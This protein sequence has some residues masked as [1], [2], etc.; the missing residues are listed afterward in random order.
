LP[1]RSPA[2]KRD[3]A[4]PAF[5]LSLDDDAGESGGWRFH[6][7]WA[8]SGPDP[9]RH[10]ELFEG[11]VFRR[12]VAYLVDVVIVGT[13]LIAAKAAAAILGVLSFGLLTPLLAVALGF[14]PLAYH[15]L[16]IG[17]PN[18][19]TLG[20]SLMR[21]EVRSW[22]GVRPSY[23]QALLMTALFYALVGLTWGLVLLWPLF[24]RRGRTLHDILSGTFVVNAHPVSIA[25]HSPAD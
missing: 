4:A 2:R 1:R 23:P 7:A 9:M 15:T 16:L 3:D 25:L 6:R 11:V 14:I 22:T 13:C 20:M 17:G 10:P 8:A 19:A 5:T 12:V 18:A 21:V 24:N